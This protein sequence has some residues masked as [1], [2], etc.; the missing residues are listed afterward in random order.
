M[1]IKDKRLFWNVD[2]NLTGLKLS[3]AIATKAGDTV[4]GQGKK[5]T[6]SL[7]KE[8]LKAKIEKVEVASNDLEG[9]YVVA[10]V[11]DMATGEVLID[12]NSELTA[13]ALSKLMESGIEEFEIFFPERDDVGT[14]IS[15]TIRKDAVK[16]Q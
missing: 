15:A 16:T 9:A 12:A 13:A 4:V 14:V 7:Y 1:E 10:D 3:H 11:V 6:P 8:L 2:E 5:I